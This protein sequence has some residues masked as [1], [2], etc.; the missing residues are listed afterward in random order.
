MAWVW[1]RRARIRAKVSAGFSG[2]FSLWFPLL[3]TLVA[4]RILLVMVPT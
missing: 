4:A 1:F 2:L 3:T